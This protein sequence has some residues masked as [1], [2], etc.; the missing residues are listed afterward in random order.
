MVERQRLRSAVMSAMQVLLEAKLP[1]RADRQIEIA[2]KALTLDPAQESAHRTLMRLYAETGQRSE[3]FRQ[4]FRCR[5]TLW[6]EF[7]IRPEPA[8]D[9]LYK[10]MLSRSRPEGAD[11]P[12]NRG[13]T[14]RMVLK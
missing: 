13:S 12:P 10:A 14:S 9:L 3:A 6:R 2:L 5:E 4:Y 7:S 1:V 11:L 8:T